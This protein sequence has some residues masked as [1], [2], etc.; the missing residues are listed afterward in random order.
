MLFDD[1]LALYRK[2]F[3]S[4]HPQTP[5]PDLMLYLQAQPDT[6]VEPI[7]RRGIPMEAAIGADDLRRLADSYSRFFHGFDAAPVLIQPAT[8]SA[9]SGALRYPSGLPLCQRQ[10][11]AHIASIPS[12][13][14]QPRS[15]AARA[16]S[17]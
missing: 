7:R 4:L 16:G 12:S 11:S 2:I 8:L 6:L 9:A 10:P 15:S 5:M 14:R 1:E 13:A 3:D 17:A